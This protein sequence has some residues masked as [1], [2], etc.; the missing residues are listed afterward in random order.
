MVVSTV[1][2]IITLDILSNVVEYVVKIVFSSTP[3]DCVSSSCTR[4]KLNLLASIPETLAIPGA[5]STDSGGSSG[6]AAVPTTQLPPGNPSS[7]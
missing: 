4:S 1:Y 2:S 3:H 7:F 5:V 6:G